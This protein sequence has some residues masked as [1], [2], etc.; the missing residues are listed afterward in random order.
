MA[1]IDEKPILMP[2]DLL[3]FLK[4]DSIPIANTELKEGMLINTIVTQAPEVW[5]T[6][7]GLKLFGP[8][9]FGFNHDYVP[10]EKLIKNISMMK[11][12]ILILLKQINGIRKT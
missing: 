4:N 10:V 1:W 6:S 3:I 9:H 2:P 5:R 11:I 12:L 8:K 7:K